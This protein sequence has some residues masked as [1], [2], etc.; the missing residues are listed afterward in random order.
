MKLF[1][2]NIPDVLEYLKLSF[3]DDQNEFEVIFGSNPYKNPIDKG[4]FLRVLEDCR[5]KYKK[6]SETIDLDITTEYR[7]KPG[8][9]RATIHG[10]D[11]IKKYCKEE[12]LKDIANIEYMQKLFIKDKPGLKDEDFNVRAK[13]KTEKI[14]DSSHYFVKSFNQDYENKGKHYRYKKRFS[15]LTNDKLFRIDLT[16]LKSTNYFKGK[17]DFQ[18]SFKKANILNNSETYEVEIE[19]VGWEKG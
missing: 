7:G 3:L 6:L 12:S 1:E 19:Y 13:V 2:K 10:I 18:K 15:F 8:N 11:D 17:Y 5:I 9:V 14:L 4:V 16:I